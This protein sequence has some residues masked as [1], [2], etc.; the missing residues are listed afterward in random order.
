[1]LSWQSRCK[2]IICKTWTNILTANIPISTAR[3][4]EVHDSNG[5]LESVV[6]TQVDLDTPMK[7]EM[8][9]NSEKSATENKHM[10]MEQLIMQ[11][12]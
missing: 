10:T 9:K 2:I 4:W 3:A 5:E 7:D 1:M 6:F 8:N 11:Y 12:T